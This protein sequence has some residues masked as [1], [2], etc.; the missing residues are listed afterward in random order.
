MILNQVKLD[1]ADIFINYVASIFSLAFPLKNLISDEMVLPVPNSLT[2]PQ[3]L[4]NELDK[5]F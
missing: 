5:T 2:L 4:E 3:L 1:R